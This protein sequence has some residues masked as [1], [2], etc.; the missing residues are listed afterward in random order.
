MPDAPHSAVTFEGIAY[1]GRPEVLALVRNIMIN[2]HGG[3]I[4]EFRGTEDELVAAGI[5]EREWFH[6]GSLSRLT[7]SNEFGG[8]Y[9][10]SRRTRGIWVLEIESD[11]ERP[12]PIDRPDTKAARIAIPALEATVAKILERFARAG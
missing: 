10:L 8:Q 11:A 9:R 3:W 7:R 1:T 12:C 4:V 5:A 6:I 2:W